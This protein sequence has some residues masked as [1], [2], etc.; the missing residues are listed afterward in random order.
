MAHTAYIPLN[1]PLGEAAGVLA[2]FCLDHRV[3]SKEVWE[4]KKLS[5]SLQ[6]KLVQQGTRLEWSESILQ[7]H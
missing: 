1:G 4:S 5:K 2:S 3:T 6:K 7:K